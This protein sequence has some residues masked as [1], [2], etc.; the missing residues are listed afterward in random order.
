M[1]ASELMLGDYVLHEEKVKKVNVIWNEHSVSLT[2][3]PPKTWG[4]IYAD[5]FETNDL[6]PVP[7][8]PEILLNNGWVLAGAHYVL[9]A[10]E[11]RL[12]WQPYGEFIL[13]YALFPKKVLYLH[14]LQHIMRDCGIEATFKL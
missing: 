13:G 2:D 1:K 11:A 14:E 12:G 9:K 7:I 3:C 4:S 6:Q 8:T 10:K 5:K